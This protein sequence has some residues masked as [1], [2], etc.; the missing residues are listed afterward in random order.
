MEEYIGKV[1]DNYITQKASKIY[2]EEAVSFVD[3]SKKLKIFYHLFG[4]DKAKSILISQKR[5]ISKK[6]TLSE[7]LSGKGKY[8]YLSYQDDEALYLPPLLGYFPSK[9]QNQTHYYWLIAMLCNI[10][11]TDNNI[12]YKNTKAYNLLI[13]RYSGFQDFWN[14]VTQIEY[15]NPFWIYPSLYKKNSLFTN[16]DEPPKREKDK[17]SKV[18]TLNSKKQAKQVDDE[19]KSDGLLLFIPES[20]MSIMERVNVD[21]QENDSFDEDALYNAEDLDE[22][23]L[24]SKDANLSAR[25]KM[26]L[27]I[28]NKN[29]EDYPI[30]KGVFIDE[31]D[32]TKNDYLKGFVRIKPITSIN[33]KE[34][35]FPKRLTKKMRE[36]QS[37]IEL[38]KL[39]RIKIDN[40]DY[41]EE[42]NIY[43]YIDYKSNQNHFLGKQNFFYSYQKKSRDIASLLLADVSLSTEAGVTQELRVIDLIKDA[44]MVFAHS[45]DKLQ[46]RFSI[47][48]FS[49]IKNK[50]VNFHIIKNFN[51]PYNNFVIGKID[52][53]K[54]GY[55]TRMGAGIRQSTKILKKQSNQNRLLLILSDGKPNDVDRYDSRYGI[56]D[57]KKA[58]DEAKAL[59]ITP[60]CI[61]IDT[62]AKDYLSYIFGKNSYATV[63]NVQKLPKI[64]TQIY[65]N[66][67]K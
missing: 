40:L 62:E 58:I 11:I 6:R 17:N 59:G 48:T 25:I 30:G 38:I 44:L 7:K 29:V 12:S 67:T 42:L 24:G 13:N 66:L 9:T 3:I 45:L 49:S 32:Y 39:D 65:I 20:L 36:I 41:G 55:Y 8:F 28:S 43:S 1:W 50:K 46:E 34:V 31:W 33:V 51:E 63:T 21:R 57:T 18:D 27:E 47:Y 14:K 35:S 64:L 26:D 56:E 37:Q 53:I 23:T 16:S 54:A 19:K 5:Y 22:I 61:T 15:P 60:F 4:G 10:D 52:A 2:V